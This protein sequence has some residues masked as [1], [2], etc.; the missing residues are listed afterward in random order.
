MIRIVI[1]DDHPVVRH[2]LRGVLQGDPEV[3]V[4]GEACDGLKATDLVEQLK[5]DVLIVDLTMPG[6][7]GLEVI[8][9][10]ARRSP[11]TRAIVFSMH[12]AE[13]YVLQSLRAGAVGYLLK[14]APAAEVL[15]AVREVSAGG[16]YISPSLAGIV[17]E[18]YSKSQCQE[19]GD[20]Y[21]SLSSRER[22]VF[23]LVAEGHSNADIARRLFISSR[24]VE[25]H[26]ASAM[27]KLGFRSHTDVVRYAL[28]RGILPPD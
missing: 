26:R 20:P 13:E 19:T 11:R 28:R 12:A 9:Q 22:E 6:L 4:V 21:E 10:S 2:G 18:A 8:H 25:T 16:G 15:A 7:N 5:P 14:G 23:Q 17:M 3:V 1:A 27:H 24:T